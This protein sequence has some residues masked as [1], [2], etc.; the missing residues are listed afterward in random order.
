MSTKTSYIEWQIQIH[1]P[2][3]SIFNQRNILK[4]F[5]KIYPLKGNIM[6]FVPGMHFGILDHVPFLQTGVELCVFWN[7]DKHLTSIVLAWGTLEPDARSETNPCDM[8][9]TMQGAVKDTYILVK[10]FL[11]KFILVCRIYL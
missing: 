6:K 5:L 3:S 10:K 4:R 11:R 8:W 7:C 2:I 9:G 1:V